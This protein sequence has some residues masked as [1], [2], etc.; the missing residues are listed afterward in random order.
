MAKRIL[1]LGAGGQLGQS[2][3]ALANHFPELEFVSANRSQFDFLQ[4]DTI[5]ALL[6]EVKPAVCINC[7][8]Y[9]AVDLAE[10]EPEK[11]QAI[12]VEAV[13]QLAATCQNMGILLV[14]FSTDYV[15]N[16]ARGEAYTEADETD[17]QSEYGRTKRDGERVIQASGAAHLI[18]RTSWLYSAFG[19]N[20]VKTMVHLGADR[21]ELTVVDDQVGTPTYAAELANTVLAWLRDG[22]TPEQYGLYHYSNEGVATWYDFAC[23]VMEYANLSARVIPVSS[24]V[25]QQ[26]AKRPS[27][28]LLAKNKIKNVRKIE[29]PHW[30]DSLR[31]YLH[32]GED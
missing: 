16:G 8:A 9:T 6:Q 24:K 11:A 29:I 25:F 2:F 31:E 5:S 20:F 15:F 23:A 17:P 22:V 4:P 1:L 26:K 13:Q 32:A 18:F 12:N 30:R 19:K 7:V 14:H 28:S 3:L 27:F 21:E 10:D